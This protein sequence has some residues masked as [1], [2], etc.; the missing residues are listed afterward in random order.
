MDAVESV[1]FSSGGE[2]RLFTLMGETVAA[3]TVVIATGAGVSKTGRPGEAKYFG[4]GISACLTCDGAFYR[5]RRVAIVGEG[6]AAAGAR[7][8]LVRCGAEV[9]AELAV[10][11]IAEFVGDGSVLTGVKDVDGTTVVCDGAF[12]V[13]ARRPQTQFLGGALALDDG[14]HVVVDE[15]RHT[16]VPGVFAAG[17]C[18]RPKF[19][20]AVV[21]AA[22]GAIAAREASAYLAAQR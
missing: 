15:A 20:Q 2:F 18:A 12:L 4:R 19:K 14:G 22:D 10:A 11:R 9:V 5:G 17:D 8:Y 16:S 13:T 1:D 3:R 21:A 7:A 6:S